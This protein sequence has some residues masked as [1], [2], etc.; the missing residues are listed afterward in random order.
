MCFGVAWVITSIIIVVIMCMTG[1]FPIKGW[2]APEITKNR[3]FNSDCYVDEVRYNDESEADFSNWAMKLYEKTGVQAYYLKVNIDNMPDIKTSWDA[4]NYAIDRAKQLTA[5]DNCAVV[6]YSTNRSN[7]SSVYI[8]SQLY[9]VGDAEKFFDSALRM[10]AKKSLRCSTE[11]YD[12]LQDILVYTRCIKSVSETTI[13]WALC[14]LIIAVILIIEPLIEWR[15]TVVKAK[16]KKEE[17][18]RKE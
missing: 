18:G 16:K 14:L 12:V 3:D 11:E 10:K 17:K 8:R 15:V 2:T 5:N 9:Y 4:R 6:I 13:H 7:E 1:V